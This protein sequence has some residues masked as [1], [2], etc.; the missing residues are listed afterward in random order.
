MSNNF[1]VG[2]VFRKDHLALSVSKIWWKD[3][4]M[5]GPFSCEIFIKKS[6]PILHVSLI[7]SLIKFLEYACP[8]F[9]KNY[10]V[11]TYFS[12]ELICTC[13]KLSN[14]LGWKWIWFQN[15]TIFSTFLSSKKKVNSKNFWFVGI[16]ILISQSFCQCRFFFPGKITQ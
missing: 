7:A 8:I 9:F 2:S 12:R 16:L 3:F 1:A 6:S 14:H 11:H 13:F 15:K 4:P 10:K 5:L